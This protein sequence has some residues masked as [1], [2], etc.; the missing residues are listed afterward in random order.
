MKCFADLHMHSTGSDGQYRP[1]KLVAIAKE[2]GLNVIAITD[3][4]SISGLKEAQAESEK[5]GITVIPGIE[6][7][8]IEYPTFHI[9]GYGFDITDP[10]LNLVF[11]DLEAGRQERKRRIMAYLREKGVDFPISEVDEMA[12]EGTVGRPHFARVMLK[13][14]ICQKWE[15]VFDTYLDTEE[16]HE[17]VDFEKPSVR[18]CIKW[19]KDAGGIVSLAHPYQIGISNEELDELVG[20]LKKQGLE[21]IECWHS[22]HTPEMTAFYLSL[23]EKYSLYVT[24]GSDF[25][26]EALKP[27]I[28]IARLEL[29]LDWLLHRN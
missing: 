3:H 23:A 13:R 11:N 20:E 27:Q 18:D 9:L 19:I 12:G 5:L 21:A 22:G 29:D 7:S 15:E 8:A 1:A 6:M 25:H 14:G 2:K 16:F 24:G 26:G 10:N 17:K 4:D 28:K